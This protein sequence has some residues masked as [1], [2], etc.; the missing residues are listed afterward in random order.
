MADSLSGALEVHCDHYQG[1]DRVEDS[2][3][4]ID[5]DILALVCH[6]CRRGWNI[7]VVSPYLPPRLLVS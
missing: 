4:A 2:D 7:R 6:A 3:V 1:A 5:L